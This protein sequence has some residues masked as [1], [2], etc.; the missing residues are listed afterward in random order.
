MNAA[1]PMAPT[2]AMPDPIVVDVVVPCPPA[3]A[4]DYFTR[5]IA[6]WWPLPTHSCAMD[7][8]VDVAFEPHVGGRIVERA[9]DGAS[10]VWGGVTAW[11]PGRRV[12]FSWHPGRGADEATWVDVKFAAHADGTRVTL[13]HG[14]WERREDGASVRGNYVGGWRNVLVERFGAYCRHALADPIAT[15]K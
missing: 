12:A 10:H 6:R 1:S 11:E 15:T 13:T 14:G 7:D 5:D 9:R 2:G 4:F 3:R 8:A